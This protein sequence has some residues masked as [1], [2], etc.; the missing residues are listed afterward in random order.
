ME[1]LANAPEMLSCNV[2]QIYVPVVISHIKRISK[3][4]SLLLL[5]RLTLEVLKREPV[6]YLQFS[7]KEASILSH[8]SALPMAS[9]YW[10]LFF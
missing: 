1:R 2:N 6:A 4:Y 7:D 10:C 3:K 8:I 5:I 9:V